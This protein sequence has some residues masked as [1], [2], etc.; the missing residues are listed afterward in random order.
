[1]V[2]IYQQTMFRLKCKHLFIAFCRDLGNAGISGTLIPDLGG[3]KN[4]QYLWELH[5]L[6][7]SLQGTGI[8]LKYAVFLK[9]SL[10]MFPV[11]C[12]TTS[13]MVPYQQHSEIWQILSAW[14]FIVIF[15]LERYRLHLAPLARCDTCM[16]FFFMQDIHMLF[17]RPPSINSDYIFSELLNAPISSG[18]YMRTTWQGLFL[19]LWAIWRVLRSWSFR[20]MRW[21]GQFHP[22]SGT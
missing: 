10:T 3:L 7:K 16:C 15:L 21:A 11:S 20:R 6:L 22:L 17:I 9:F 8:T 4:L 18:G 13:W 12:T 2:Y 1:M 19:N 5:S 14:I